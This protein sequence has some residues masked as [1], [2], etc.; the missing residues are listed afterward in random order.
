MEERQGE[1]ERRAGRLTRERETKRNHYERETEEETNTLNPPSPPFIFLHPC[2][3]TLHP[4][5]FS[6]YINFNT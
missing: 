1:Y 5:H 6:I 2:L 3:T 4:L